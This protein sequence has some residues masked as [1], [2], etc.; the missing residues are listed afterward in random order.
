MFEKEVQSS[1]IKKGN[2]IFIINQCF[3][4]SLSFGVIVLFF[5]IIKSVKHYAPTQNIY[6]YTEEH[7]DT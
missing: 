7:Q 4:I 5:R 3:E 2:L 6:T 1:T